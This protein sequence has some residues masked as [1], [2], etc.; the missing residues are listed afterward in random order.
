MQQR[1]ADIQLARSDVLLAPGYG[2]LIFR[3]IVLHADHVT[4]HLPQRSKNRAPIVF[5]IFIRG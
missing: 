5:Q 2:E 3:G 1:H 4:S